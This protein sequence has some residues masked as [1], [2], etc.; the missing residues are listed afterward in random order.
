[1]IISSMQEVDIQTSELK[2]IFFKLLGLNVTSIERIGGG[3]NSQVYRLIC[4][5]SDQYAAKL[6]FRHSFDE[7]DRLGSEFSGLQFLWENG[8]R[9]ISRPIVADRER[10]CA[11]YEYI[12]GKKIQSQEVTNSDVDYAVQFLA[13]LKELKNRKGSSYLPLASEACFSVQAIVNNIELR[14]NRLSAL[15]N[16]GAQYNALREFLTN[17]FVPSFDEITR[18]CKSSLNQSRMS[19]V[20]E[21][22]Y[23][24]R[25]LSPSD[26]GF[27]NALRRSGGQIVF[28]DFEYFGWDDPAKMI[29]DFLLHP[30]MELREELRRRFVSSTLSCFEDYKNLDKR[31]EIVYPL[32]GLKWCMIFLNEF[33]P[34]S[35]LRREFASGGDLDKSEVQAKQLLKARQMLHR[36]RRDYEHFPYRE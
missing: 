14:L 12:E 28:L 30:A 31:V 4:G 11:V 3:R 15:R 13:R 18:W 23:E 16:G 35:L 2:F 33:V 1:M 26:F 8:V 22:P 21:L 9:C 10:G 34:E 36:I 7:R 17:D 5:S 20:S 6:Y 24:E 32:F 25:T 29:S 19:F 27:H